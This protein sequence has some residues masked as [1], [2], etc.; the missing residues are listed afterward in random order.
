MAEYTYADLQI[1]NDDVALDTAGNP[2]FIYDRDVIAQD[3]VHT[4]RES[5][6]LLPLIGERRAAKRALVYN[7]VAILVEEDERVTPG[8]CTVAES[9]DAINQIE[10]T[11]NTEFGEITVSVS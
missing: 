8:S 7:K 5:G 1:V 3:L 6:V 10:I 2:V 4:I 11:A 9:D